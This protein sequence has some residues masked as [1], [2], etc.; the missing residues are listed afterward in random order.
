[1]WAISSVKL[2]I[3]LPMIIFPAYRYVQLYIYHG[4]WRED[5]ISKIVRF[6]RLDESSKYCMQA[7]KKFN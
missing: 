2:S 1:M 4:Q 5:G 3:E 7:S 6:L